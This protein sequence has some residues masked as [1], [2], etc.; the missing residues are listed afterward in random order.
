[1]EIQPQNQK[2]A[3]ILAFEPLDI[4]LGKGKINCKVD[5]SFFTIFFWLPVASK[6]FFSFILLRLLSEQIRKASAEQVYLVL[7][8]NESLVAED[9]M[10]KALEVISETC[11]DGDMD[12]AKHKRL[13][14]SN[15]LGLDV[16]PISVSKDSDGASR[17]ISSKSPA[18]L[19]ENASYSSLVE[20]SGF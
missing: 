18:D 5:K 14:L 6:F 7:L 3:T 12:L 8:Q 20:S 9:K 11:W 4:S 17:K 19:D 15:L 16:G 2:E 13:E 10:E 1:M